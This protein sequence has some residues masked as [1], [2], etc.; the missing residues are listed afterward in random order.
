MGGRDCCCDPVCGG[1]GLARWAVMAAKPDIAL[2]FW[3]FHPVFDVFWQRLHHGKLGQNFAFLND[4]KPQT[5]NRNT[6]PAITISHR[7]VRTRSRS[8][9]PA[10][11][12]PSM[13]LSFRSLSHPYLL[14]TPQVAANQSVRERHCERSEAISVSSKLRIINRLLHFVRNDAGRFLHSRTE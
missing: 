7:A 11:A 1:I 5:T 10:I 14:R 13:P 4:S 9:S 8:P 6:I 3:G 12:T 2:R